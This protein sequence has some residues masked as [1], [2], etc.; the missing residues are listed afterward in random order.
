M[1][2]C[3]YILHVFLFYLEL[4]YFFTSFFGDA[5][6]IK[7]VK[8]VTSFEYNR[9]SLNTQEAIIPLLFHDHSLVRG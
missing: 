8:V 5:S 7:M 3:Q 9:K 2:L 4:S 1:I 6:A